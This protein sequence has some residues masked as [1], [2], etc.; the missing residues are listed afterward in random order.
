[1]EV[2]SRPRFQ[3]LQDGTLISVCA[4]HK[5]RG[6]GASGTHALDKVS[7]LPVCRVEADHAGIG[8]L[9]HGLG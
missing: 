6:T 7:A 2:A 5:N 4:D 9:P 3:G 8:L 1:V